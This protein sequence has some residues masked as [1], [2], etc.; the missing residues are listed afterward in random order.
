MNTLSRASSSR[1]FRTMTLELLVAAALIGSTVLTHSQQKSASTD[2]V[3][4]SSKDPAAAQADD[5][6]PGETKNPTGINSDGL[7]SALQA[8]KQT[9]TSIGSTELPLWSEG[10]NDSIEAPTQAISP[11]KVTHRSQTLLD[12]AISNVHSPTLTFHFPSKELATGTLVI[13]CPGGFYESLNID[14]EGH[15]VARWLNSMGIAAAVL[16]YRLPRAQNYWYGPEKPLTDLRRSIRAVRAAASDFS[17]SPNRIGVMGFSTGGHLAAMEAVTFEEAD[18][19]TSTSTD[20]IDRLSCRPDFLILAYPITSLEDRYAPISVKTSFLGGRFDYK[21]VRE[22]SPVYHVSDKMP[23]TFI[24]HATDDPFNS[25]NSVIFYLA[26]KQAGVTADLHIYAEGGHGY[27][28]ANNGLYVD[29]WKDRCADWLAALGATTP[30][31]V[32]QP[33]PRSLNEAARA[34]AAARRN[35]TTR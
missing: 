33:P 17:I 18:R 28:I 12:R 24:V 34:R 14:K 27:G 16:K 23:S 10:P 2:E 31:P 9:P 35:R 1:R 5:K 25:E 22:F 29:S 7:K 11:I 15:D 4:E 19:S 32:A 30:A 26:L 6:S 3:K 13:I 20:P 8:Q 21:D